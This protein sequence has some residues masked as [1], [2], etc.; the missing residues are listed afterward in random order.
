MTWAYA[1]VADLQS[2]LRERGSELVILRGLPEVE[3]PRLAARVAATKVYC[4]RYAG[5]SISA[6]HA[7][8]FLGHLVVCS[9]IL[10]Y[11]TL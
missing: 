9:L 4:H 5:I 3:I 10:P 7:D 11:I 8:K 1:G 6:F 2:R